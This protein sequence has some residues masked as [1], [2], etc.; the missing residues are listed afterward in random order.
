[1]NPA[2]SDRGNADH[3]CDSHFHVFGPYAR[4]PLSPSASYRPPEATIDAY[5]RVKKRLGISRMVV[6]QGGCYGTDNA[7]MLEAVRELGIDSARG[8]AIVDP[9]IDS[10]A[11]ARMHEGGV[12]AIRINAISDKSVDERSIKTL[13]G[14]IASVGWHIQFHASPEQVTACEATLGSL[15]VDVC[16][17]H[18]GRVDPR[19]GVDQAPIVSMLRLLDRGKCWVKVVSYRSAVAGRARTEMKPIVS[20]IVREAPE[21]CVW[22]TDWPHPLLDEVPD[23]MDL[24]SDIQ[25][26]LDDGALRRMVLC[27]NPAKLYGF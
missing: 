11:L 22:G 24:L 20:K 12:R 21:R 23:T 7:A 9:E 19:A 8:V 1:M 17:D 26:F 5:R 2:V 15:P 3:I 25:A 10:T 6:V 14:K 27:S 13:A 4:F 16:I 18:C